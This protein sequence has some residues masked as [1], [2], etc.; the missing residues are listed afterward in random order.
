MGAFALY[1]LRLSVASFLL[2]LILLK[3]HNARVDYLLLRWIAVIVRLA[4]PEKIEIFRNEG[5][6]FE[7]Y[8]VLQDMGS[9]ALRAQDDR[10]SRYTLTQTAPPLHYS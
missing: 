3:R 9:F 6:G 5:R 4:G 2:I 7:W 10:C 1:L 8:I